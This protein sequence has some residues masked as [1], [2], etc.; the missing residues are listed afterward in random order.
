MIL[1]F[2]KDVHLLR[3]ANLKNANSTNEC[4]GI[5]MTGVLYSCTANEYTY[6]NNGNLMKDSNKNIC[7][8]VHDLLILLSTM[9]NRG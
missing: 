4:N 9:N 7:T 3:R 5:I 1:L 8:I 6:D 2:G